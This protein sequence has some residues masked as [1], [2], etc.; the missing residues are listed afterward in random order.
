MQYLILTAM[1]LVAVEFGIHIIYHAVTGK[2]GL[3]DPAFA[4]LK[5]IYRG[6]KKWAAR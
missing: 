3:Y 6:L 5:D 2:A 4:Y 1:T